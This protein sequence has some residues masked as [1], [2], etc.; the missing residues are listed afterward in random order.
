[1]GRGTGGPQDSD[2]ERATL[3]AWATALC[4]GAWCVELVN[5]TG[6]SARI[7]GERER[8]KEKE[9]KR[10]RERERER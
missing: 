2:R 10:K 3:R 6:L 7:N 8:E 1:M 5:R 4:A 9:R